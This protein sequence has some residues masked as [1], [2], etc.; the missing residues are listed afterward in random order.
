MWTDDRPDRNPGD[1]AGFASLADVSLRRHAAEPGKKS[2]I[3]DAL[4]SMRAA[5]EF[6]RPEAPVVSDD[7][8]DVTP[9]VPQD[10]VAHWNSL[11]ATRE[12]PSRDLLRISDLAER[13]PDSILFRCGSADQIQP[14]PA[15]A[16]SL[17]ACRN[18]GTKS[19]FEGSAEV[20][21]LLSQWILSIARDTVQ[22]SAPLRDTTS[23][24]TAGGA[25]NFNIAAVPFGT[26]AVDHVL[27]VVEG[28]SAT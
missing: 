1:K 4:K 9:A 26:N 11:R 14:D 18:G 16:A 6:V 19:I 10:I 20:S 8:R 2:D 17:R 3:T 27:C 24:D 5:P 25:L 21:A 23:F 22:K 13:W 7:M 12:M 15:F 28:G